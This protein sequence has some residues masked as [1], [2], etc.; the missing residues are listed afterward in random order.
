MIYLDHCQ[1]AL[2][3]G[4]RLVRG[5][6]ISVVPPTFVV[7]GQ[8]GSH[9]LKGDHADLP[10]CGDIVEALVDDTFGVPQ[11]VD[12]VRLVAPAKDPVNHTESL[13]YRLHRDNGRIRDLLLLKSRALSLVRSFFA[14]RGFVEWQT[15][16]LV[17]SPGVEVHLQGFVTHY[18]DAQ[19]KSQRY[20]LPTS[21]EFALKKALCAG[22]ERI[23]EIGR[24]F[25]N[26]ETGPLHQCEFT[27]IEWYRAFVDYRDIMA[28]LE[29]LGAYLKEQLQGVD[30]P[31][32]RGRRI[33]WRPPW[34]RTSLQ[35]VFRRRCQIDLAQG[36]EDPEYFRAE[37]RRLLGEGVGVQDFDSI[38]FQLFLTF[39]EPHLGQDKPEIV[40]DYP[41]SMAALAAAKPD[42]PSFAE[43][44]ELYVAGVELANAFTELNDPQE[45]TVRFQQALREKKRLGYPEVPIDRQFLRELGHGMPPAAGIALGLERLLMVLTGTEDIAALLFLPHQRDSAASQRL[46]PLE[47]S[48]Q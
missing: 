40:Y 37:A 34:T 16:R 31:R 5:R 6:V 46:W 22:M 3:P 43:R 1:L 48:R 38:F 8:D 4:K 19:G 24:C 42:Q 17:N 23:Y 29:E 9:H 35:D 2:T 26:G 11:V 21:P 10:D 12:L 33:D 36:I 13:F 14:A 28:D 44:F 7:A 39:V 18:L 41:I 20:Y 15:P 32:F 30:S 47:D 45:Q 25:R 27:M